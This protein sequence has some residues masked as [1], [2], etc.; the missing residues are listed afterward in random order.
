MSKVPSEDLICPDCGGNVINHLNGYKC[1]KCG[2]T[3]EVIDNI[4]YAL[5]KS[6]DKFA[7]REDIAYESKE[8]LLGY[9][10]EELYENPWRILFSSYTVKQGLHH[11]K[12]VVPFMKEK[13]KILEVGAGLG[14]TALVSKLHFPQSIIYITDVSQKAVKLAKRLFDLF[15]LGGCH[16]FC[17]LDVQRMPFKTETFDFIYCY[18]V[19]HHVKEPLKF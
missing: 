3:L 7:I 13:S 8:R 19:V 15:Q 6:L 10:F 4:L 17:V 14:I 16:Y 5:P 18:S 9:R 1:Q 11:E 2:R 12:D